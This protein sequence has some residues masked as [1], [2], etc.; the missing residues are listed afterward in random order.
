M[1]QRKLTLSIFG[2]L[3][4]LSITELTAQLTHPKASPA[5]V[6]EQAVGLSKITVRYSRPA[7]RGR[8]IFGGLVPYGR[9][10]RVGANESTKIT[11]DTEMEVM[12]KVLPKGTYA[13]YAFPESN[14]WE[15]AFHTNLTHWGDGRKNYNPVED[16]FRISV[17]PK[18]MAGHQ[19][20]FLI[21]F[22]DISHNSVQMKLVWA[23]TQVAI[24][25]KVDTHAQM[26]REISIKLN[27]SPTAQTYYE[28]ARYLQE[29]HKDPRRALDYLNKALE[30]GGDT[31]YFHR[32]KS[33]VEAELGDYKS[34]IA[35]AKRSLKI[36]EK[37]EKDEFVRMNQKNIAKWENLLEQK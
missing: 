8:T 35:S 24:P 29:Q 22:D 26:E 21:T 23:N 12:G 11:V 34:A 31:Y 5:S 10:W 3:F 14:A 33:L 13:L 6:V 7:V 37:L 36:A 19:E 18:K 16:L 20:N 25:F 9:I 32:V 4:V 15:I 2:L 30:L 17:R 28:A 27:E 1:G